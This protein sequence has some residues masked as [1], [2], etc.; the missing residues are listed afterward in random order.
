MKLPMNQYAWWPIT[1]GIKGSY[2]LCGLLDGIMFHDEQCGSCVRISLWFF[3]SGRQLSAPLAV[4]S[5]LQL[6]S[7]VLCQ[8]AVNFRR[9]F[10]YDIYE[11]YGS[12]RKCGLKFR[13]KFRHEKVPSR[14][15]IHNLVSKL[16]STGLSIDKKQKH[17][18]QMLAEK[19]LHDVGI[20]LEP[21]P[22]KWQNV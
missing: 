5:Q 12:A 22:R 16:G 19:R 4:C 2:W 18:C 21:T 20:R 15:T 7:S 3:S 11:K 14:Q 13:R 9:V 6:V 8:G 10:L 1:F 17:K